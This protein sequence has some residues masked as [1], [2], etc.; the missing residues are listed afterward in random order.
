MCIKGQ[1]LFINNFKIEY[2]FFKMC[3]NVNECIIYEKDGIQ[4]FMCEYKE[5]Q[6]YL[7]DCFVQCCG[8]DMCNF[9]DYE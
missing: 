2:I 7:V 9:G 8:D 4:V 5:N 6:G 3:V 1:I